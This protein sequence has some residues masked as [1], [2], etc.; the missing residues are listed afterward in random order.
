MAE[1][2]TFS[3]N[4]TE[5]TFT[6]NNGHVAFEVATNIETLQPPLPEP[7]IVESVSLANHHETSLELGVHDLVV[8]PPVV[9][10]L[11]SHPFEEQVAPHFDLLI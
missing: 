11:A 9:E 1:P 2:W 8:P 6:F 5:Q 4:A 10:H 7:V 3:F